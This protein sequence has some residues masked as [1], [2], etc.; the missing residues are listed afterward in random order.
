LISAERAK[1][2]VERTDRLAR[3]G[4]PNHDPT[5]VHLVQVECV[6]GLTQLMEHVVGG[7][8]DVVDGPCADRAKAA[9]QPR[10]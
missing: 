6:E 2:A 4:A 3:S 9:P 5:L 8:D 1:H 10:G 7:I